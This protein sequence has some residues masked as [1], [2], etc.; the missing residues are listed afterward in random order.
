QDEPRRI[1]LTH[2]RLKQ[3]EMHNVVTTV[4]GKI[5]CWSRYSG[6]CPSPHVAAR[7]CSTTWEA[8][9]GIL[10]ISYCSLGSAS[11]RAQRLRRRAARLGGNRWMGEEFK[12]RIPSF[13]VGGHPRCG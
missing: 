2:V 8:R 9:Q 13:H 6:H 12:L 4:S 1:C 3:P 11:C 10:P 5:A 7:M